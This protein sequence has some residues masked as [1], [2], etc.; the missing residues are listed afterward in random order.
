MF[1]T[2]LAWKEMFKDILGKSFAYVLR[3]FYLKLA[4]VPKY[5]YKV[6]LVCGKLHPKKVQI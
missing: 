1:Q 6:T 5:F 2:I 3:L 4:F